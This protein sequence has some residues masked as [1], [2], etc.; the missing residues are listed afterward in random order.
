MLARSVLGSCA[1]LALS[2]ALGLRAQVPRPPSPASG[3]QTLEKALEGQPGPASFTLGGFTVQRLQPAPGAKP[4]AFSGKGWLVLPPPLGGV[5]VAFQNLTLAG[6][7]ATGSLDAPLM[8][9]WSADYQGWRWAAARA[10]ISDQGS[11]LE[12]TLTAGKLQV[13]V[14]TAAFTPAGLSGSLAL[15]D[16][17]LAEGPFTATLE[18][19]QITFQAAPPILKGNLHL[20]L[21]PSFHDA[22]TGLPVDL[23]APASFEGAALVTGV[24]AD[25]LASNLGVE[26]RGLVFRFPGLALAMSEGTPVLRGAARLAFPLQTFCLASDTGRAY[27]SQPATALFKGAAPGAL[28]IRP[29]QALPP[30][31]PLPVFKGGAAPPAAGFGGSF[32]LPAATLLP[33]GLATYH[34]ALSG[35]TAVV[36]DGVLDPASTKVS[37]SLLW[38]AGWASE[39]DF[40]NAPAD[41]ADGLYLT[42][43]TLKGEVAVGAYGVQC[44]LPSAVCDFSTSRSAGGLPAAW[45]GVYLPAW[46]LALPEDIYQFDAAWDRLTTFVQAQGGA[47]EADG[48][49][50]GRA[51]VALGQTVYLQCMPVNL[52]PFQVEFADGALLGMPQV[53]GRTALDQ[54]PLLPAFDL[55][56]TF[57]LTQ[58]GARKIL[59]QTRTAAGDTT[60]RTDLVGIDLVLSDA[61]LNPTNLDLAGRFD[62]HLKGAALPSIPFD[63]LVLEAMGGGFDG[64]KGPIAFAMAGSLWA[65]VQGQPSL[66]LWG[67]PFG[68][69]EDGYGTL[70]DGRFFVGVGGEIGINPVLSGIYN[71]FLF[72]SDK[73]D[74]SKGTVETEKPFQLDHSL[75][76][77]G[78][79]QG[80]LG[81]T[82][83]T[84]GDQVSDAYFLGSGKLALT[85]S[86]NPLY[87]QA[88]LRFGQSFV[89][90]KP[91]PYFYLLGE[92]TFPAAGIDVAPDVEIYGIAGGLTQNFMPDQ[93][94]NT[95]T[96][97]G[98]EDDSLG[99]AIMAGVDVGTSDEFTFHGSLDL[100]V[101]QN[102]SVLLQGQGFLLSGRED[103]PP[104]RTVSAD[105]SF[106]RNPDAFHAVL[107]ADLGFPS[108]IIESRGTVELRFDPKNHFVHIGTP[109]APLSTSFLK[110]FA[111]GTSYLDADLG[112]GKAA[113]RA[114]GGFSMDT[115]DRD[116]GVV[117]GRLYVDVRGDLVVIIDSGLSPA[118]QG[119]LAA[120][121]GAEFGMEF[122]TFW[123][124]YRLTIFSG[125]LS[126]NLAMQVPGSPTLDGHVDISYSVL[127][128]M[129]SGTAGVD[130]EF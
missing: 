130:M 28:A 31:I 35:G 119:V 75:M 69:Q 34:L 120:Q 66:S 87:L 6:G 14:D 103:S 33:S 21:P 7:V 82:V 2:L 3:L 129:F 105:V 22:D 90:P 89:K 123:Q 24:L 128:G 41:L 46:L 113:F 111:T 57:D 74:P 122:S 60:L 94:Q 110:R 83:E 8:A 78:S 63:H 50:S 47:F 85:F 92:A 40:Q 4:S 25:P 30:R 95:Q 53:T 39:V 86:D 62:F 79:V 37:G 45:K 55:P 93:I 13:V 67:F 52:D 56:L 61:A 118:F 77:L 23:S 91:F 116:F 17:P 121:G 88:G 97:T 26:S 51:A 96:I 64:K 29:A 36:A 107:Q 109:D 68:L 81:F 9:G 80:S 32:P 19:A 100:Y 48:G 15:G 115:G 101:S 73:A 108:D 70:G 20:V 38:G 125:S 65:G 84:A 71:R 99:M 126:A 106:T 54:P 5:E 124:T 12:G 58:D 98:K 104:D 114:G 44:S 43:G 49:F 11:H 1:P 102:L 127:G 72:T 10:R 112:G 42:Q 76:D 18:G 27:L 117:Y 16:V 59:L